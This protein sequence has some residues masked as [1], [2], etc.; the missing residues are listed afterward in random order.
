M[1]NMMLNYEPETI[2]A[3][4]MQSIYIP[5]N[6]LFTNRVFDPGNPVPSLSF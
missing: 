4:P 1:Y 6:A 3:F 2:N 5:E